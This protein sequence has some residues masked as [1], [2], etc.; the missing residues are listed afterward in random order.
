M[1]RRKFIKNIGLSV[2]TLMLT[3]NLFGQVQS[4]NQ[5][6]KITILH[7]NDTHSNIDSFPSNHPLYPNQGGVSKRFE[8]IQKIRKEEDNVILLDAG[9][10]FQGSPYFNLFGGVLEMKM[11]TEDFTN[12]KLKNQIKPYSIVQKGNLKIGVFGIGIELNGLV[13]LANFE[14][15]V[16]QDPILIA[17]QIAKELKNQ[18]CDL[19]I[20][21]SHLGF[22]YP[23][24]KISDKILAKET[25]NIDI[26]IGGHTHTILEKP[27]VTQNK[28][29]ENVIINQVGWAGLF[30]GRIDVEI[31]QEY[32]LF[33]NSKNK[34]EII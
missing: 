22:E 32:K 31:H 18:K 14:G 20:C 8:L 6:K 12:S 33:K 27:F 3:P 29:Q 4:K 16:Y 28:N 21:L 30:L 13:P 9:D 1:E 5:L 15:V 24:D 17:N 11:M 34:L 7:T 23:T 19:I 25:E 2:G 10:V 26:I